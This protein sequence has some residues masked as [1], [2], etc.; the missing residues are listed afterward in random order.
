MANGLRYFCPSK[1]QVHMKINV[2]G[3]LT[4]VLFFSTLS[5]FSQISIGAQGGATFSNPSI[6]PPSGLSYESSSKTGFQ[7]GL[8][9]DIP[10][11]EGGLRLMPELKY[12]NKVHGVSAIVSIPVQGTLNYT[13]TSNISYIEVPLNLAY[14]FGSSTKFII[15]AGPY[16]AYGL[17]G[18]NDYSIT[19]GTTTVG[20][21]K[22]DIEFGSGPT[23]VKRLD[24]GAHA[25]AGV[26]FQNGF[27]V[28]VNYGL[29]LA[30]LYSSDTNGASYK[31]SY[32]GASLVYFFKR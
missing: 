28:K 10:L 1:N 25:M 12:A 22:E 23:E 26:L 31:Q 2:K 11:G 17:S 4:A 27:L 24:Y 13:G 14:A 29:G 9:F 16:V 30:N 20:S 6:K 18:K 21:L 32:L 7:A 19:S 8:I 5:T 3:V 15:G